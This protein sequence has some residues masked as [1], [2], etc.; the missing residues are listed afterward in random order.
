MKMIILSLK[1]FFHLYTE[2]VDYTDGTNRVDFMAGSDVGDVMCVPYPTINDNVSE[3]QEI[4]VL[5]LRASDED[6]IELDDAFDAT[7]VVIIDNDSKSCSVGTRM[8][9]VG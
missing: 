8:A 2:G 6:L 9:S 1:L 4:F 7:L 5:D 3:F